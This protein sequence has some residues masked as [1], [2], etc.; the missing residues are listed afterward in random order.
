MVL[1]V[2]YTLTP[3]D[4]PTST[5]CKLHN[6][7][8]R[9]RERER[10]LR[11]EWKIWKIHLGLTIFNSLLRVLVFLH[12]LIFMK[13]SRFINILITKNPS[14]TKC[15]YIGWY[16]PWSCRP[17]LNYIF[18][19]KLWCTLELLYRYASLMSKINEKRKWL[20]ITGATGFLAKG[21][22]TLKHRVLKQGFL[23]KIR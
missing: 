10:D 4:N 3:L 14:K 13:F 8:Q 9:E 2:S 11:Y 5:Y 6:I 1:L 15:E 21:K 16:I 23:L 18:L 7:V 17:D 20:W 22:K 12:Q 19:R